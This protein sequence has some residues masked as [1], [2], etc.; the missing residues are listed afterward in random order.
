LEKLSLES[1]N[2]KASVIMKQNVINFGDER[3]KQ[4]LRSIELSKKC[5]DPKDFFQKVY[6]AAFVEKKVIPEQLFEGVR[7]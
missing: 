1:R 4:L 5:V 7:I 6:N 3:M 2:I